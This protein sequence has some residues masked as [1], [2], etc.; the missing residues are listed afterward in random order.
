MI[1]KKENFAESKEYVKIDMRNL[2]IKGDIIDIG[3]K[4]YGII[5]KMCKETFDEVALDY[6]VGEEKRLIEREH[7]D[8]AILF[9]TLSLL[10]NSMKRKKL[11]NEAWNYIK[12]DGE[13]LL[14]DAK[15]SFGKPINLEVD[16]LFDNC[17]FETVSIKNLNPVIKLELS[18]VKKIMAP[19]F[20]IV[21]EKEGRSIF[22]IRARRKK[23]GKHK[24][25]TSIDSIKR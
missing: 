1:R 10:S 22:F 12:E 2:Q 23:K 5:Y 24:D 7:Y 3:V 15:K 21:E 25:E 20:D 11:I 9:F 19:Y 16:V 13:L 18:N 17:E 4:N 8:T 14:W 6:I